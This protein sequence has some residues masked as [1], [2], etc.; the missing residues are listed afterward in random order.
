MSQTSTTPTPGK[1][2]IQWVVAGALAGALAA[3]AF[4]VLAFSGFWMLAPLG[5]LAT[6]QTIVSARQ[7][8]PVLSLLCGAFVALI[9][10]NTLPTIPLMFPLSAAAPAETF[11]EAPLTEVLRHLSKASGDELPR[12]F[13]VATRELGDMR[14]TMTIPSDANLRDAL[15][16][17]MAKTGATYSWRW[18]K[19]CGLSSSPDCAAFY[20]SRKGEAKRDRYEHELIISRGELLAN[21]PEAF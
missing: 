6:A 20:I 3:I 15:D 2:S 13:Y 10:F 9:G 17:L 12:R 8:R 1:A 14:V 5:V 7:R 21:G 19:M 16:S 4:P 18:Y 11:T